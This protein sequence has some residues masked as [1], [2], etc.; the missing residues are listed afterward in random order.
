MDPI[1]KKVAARHIEAGYAEI[2]KALELG[3]QEGAT[4]ETE[5]NKQRF[6]SSI[7]QT[8]KSLQALKRGPADYKNQLNRI[9]GGLYG[10]MLNY[11]SLA[12]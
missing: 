2:T 9:G 5:F 6:E 8:C 1:A 7:D 4:W 10:V 11:G 12:K 3:R